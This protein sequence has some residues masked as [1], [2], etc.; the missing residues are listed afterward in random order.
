MLDFNLL[1]MLISKNSQQ[2]IKLNC[3]TAMERTYRNLEM[4]PEGPINEMYTLGYM[5]YITHSPIDYVNNVMQIKSQWQRGCKM[6]HK[7]RRYR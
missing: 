1:T 7:F 6:D 2:S 5:S 4:L 3:V